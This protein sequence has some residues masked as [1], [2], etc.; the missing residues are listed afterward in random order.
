MTT[1]TPAP[2][3]KTKEPAQAFA[4]FL[5]LIQHGDFHHECS[6]QL[7]ELCAAMNQHV[8]DFGGKPKGRITISIDMKLDKGCFQIDA[9][10]AVKSPRP[11]AA[12]SIMWSTP[13]NNLTAEHPRQISMFDRDRAPPAGVAKVAAE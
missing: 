8:Q 5:A 2:A 11:P 12:G 3:A 13:G 7:Q 9:D 10:L 1:D 6:T 4:T